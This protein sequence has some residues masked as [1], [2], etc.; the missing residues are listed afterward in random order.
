MNL[1]HDKIDQ[2]VLALMYLTLHDGSRAWKTFCWDAMNRLHDKALIGD[3]VSRAK[4]VVLTEKGLREAE[5]LCRELF[6]LK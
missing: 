3:P 4:S 5:Q 1:D 6:E 2:T